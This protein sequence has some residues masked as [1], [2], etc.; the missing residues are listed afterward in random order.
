MVAIRKN[1]KDLTPEE[2]SAFIKALQQLKNKKNVKTTT[3]YNEFVA[4]HAALM[5][6]V[7]KNTNLRL[8]LGHHLA[9]FLPWHRYFLLKMEE[10]LQVH[11]LAISIFASLFYL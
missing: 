2:K 7:Q 9:S 11:S 1:V 4:I 10:E 5:T 8:S 6:I 3:I